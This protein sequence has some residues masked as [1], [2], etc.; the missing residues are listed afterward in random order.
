MSMWNVTIL[1]YCECL[2]SVFKNYWFF[3]AGRKCNVHRLAVWYARNYG[4]ATARRLLW[5]NVYSRFPLL[6][7]SCLLCI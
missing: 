1:S 3:L 6:F 7:Q 4:V 2:K 5:D